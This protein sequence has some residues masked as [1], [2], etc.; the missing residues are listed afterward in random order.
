MSAADELWEKL[1]KFGFDREEKPD[2]F[3]PQLPAD[4]TSLDDRQLMALYGEYVSWTA[5]AAMRLVE[6]RANVRAAKQNLDYAT[7]RAALAA[8]TEKTVAGRKAAAGADP[9]VQE[10][11]KRHLDAVA[12]AEGLEM[13][14]KNS[15]ARANF[16]SRD[17][18]RRQNSASDS[19]YQKWGV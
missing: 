4:I 2:G 15:E 18:S 12:L 6:A 14:H 16:C 5:Y 19:R 3:L 11:E 1:E 10:D 8:S 17:L 13:V 7:A 9:Q